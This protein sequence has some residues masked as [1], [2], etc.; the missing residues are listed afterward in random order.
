MKKP[1]VELTDC[2]QCCICSD[3]CPDVFTMNDLG[4]VEVADI[5][6]YPEED[7]DD[8]I[9]NCPGNCIFWSGE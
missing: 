2:I 9:K 8:V 3:I 1:V 4:F 5:D 6:E 7:V